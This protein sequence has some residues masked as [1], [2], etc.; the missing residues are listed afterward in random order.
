MR[1]SYL[2]ELGHNQRI[3]R[4]LHRHLLTN[5]NK[6]RTSVD[7]S[8]HGSAIAQSYVVLCVNNTAAKSSLKRHAG[9]ALHSKCV[10]A[11]LAFDCGELA[12]TGGNL[13]FLDLAR[14]LVA[15]IRTVEISLGLALHEGR[16][17]VHV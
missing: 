11:S 14:F 5:Q 2:R 15:L 4:T 1:Y 12:M 8:K 13:H 3:P 6:S 9:F 10:V 7:L 17:D 16:Y